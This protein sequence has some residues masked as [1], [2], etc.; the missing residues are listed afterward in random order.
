MLVSYVPSEKFRSE[1]IKAL[2]EPD[3]YEAV[4]RF[5]SLYSTSDYFLLDDIQF[6]ATSSKTNETLFNVFNELIKNN[7]QIIMTSDRFPEKL[8]GFEKRLIS[9]F[10]SGLNVELK[11]LDQETSMNILRYKLASGEFEMDNDAQEYIASY[12]SDDVRKINSIINQ[13]DFNIIQ[14][15]ITSPV[16]LKQ[17]EKIL[18][19]YDLISGQDITPS[20]IKNVVSKEY[21]TNVTVL[22]GKLRAQPYAFARQL[23]MKL[24]HELLKLNYTQIGMEFGGRDHSTVLHAIDKVDKTLKDDKN[25][26]KIYKKIKK[27]LTKQG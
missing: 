16:T 23:A 12:Y 21:S 3:R 8:N 25:V 1:L 15:V 10:M 26:T 22:E 5:K 2:G 14:G 18:V 13:I 7:K 6:L 19:N 4:E 17:V 27:T 9:R 24:C 20:L 11:S